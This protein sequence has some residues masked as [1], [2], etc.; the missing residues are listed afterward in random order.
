MNVEN[1]D[2]IRKEIDRVVDLMFQK[3]AVLE[4]IASLKKDIKEQFD[5]PVATITKIATL[6]RKQNL[7]EEDAKWKMIKE[8]AE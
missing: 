6:I 3:E 5:I 4:Q 2:E 7:E 1:K 8:L